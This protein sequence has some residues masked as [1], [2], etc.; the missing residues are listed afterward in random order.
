MR[1]NNDLLKDKGG[2]FEQML[3]HLKEAIEQANQIVM[4][5]RALSRRYAVGKERVSQILSEIE[6]LGKLDNVQCIID[7]S[8]GLPSSPTHRDGL[9]DQ[10]ADYQEGYHAGW[11]EHVRDYGK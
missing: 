8:T 7:L 2:T 9:E 10:S 1:I 3:P 5:T 11:N 6:K 4:V